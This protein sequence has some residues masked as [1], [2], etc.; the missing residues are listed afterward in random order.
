MLQPGT[1]EEVLARVQHDLNEALARS[2]R[3]HGV[4]AR[5][6]LT[7]EDVAEIRRLRGTGAPLARIAAAFNISV[8]YCSQVLSGT[9]RIRRHQPDTGSQEPS[10]QGLKGSD[11]PAE[12]LG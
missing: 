10:P 4:I 12:T 9:R 5:R 7:D 1:A 6:R 2:L 11:S 8:P 3:R